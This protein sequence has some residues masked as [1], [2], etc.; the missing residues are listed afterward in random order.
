MEGKLKGKV[1]VIQKRRIWEIVLLT[2]TLFNSYHIH[3][4]LSKICTVDI[5]FPVLNGHK[6]IS[7]IVTYLIS[8]AKFYKTLK[9]AI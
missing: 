4:C 7:E 5:Y 6:T 1:E 3:A 9:A 2:Y 8:A